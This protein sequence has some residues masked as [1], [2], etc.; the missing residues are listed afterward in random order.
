MGVRQKLKPENSNG[1]RCKS[2]VEVSNGG[3][4]QIEGRGFKWR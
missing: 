3:E 4:V 2:K 1:V